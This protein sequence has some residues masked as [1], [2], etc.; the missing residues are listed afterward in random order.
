MKTYHLSNPSDMALLQP[1][2]YWLDEDYGNGPYIVNVFV[3]KKLGRVVTDGCEYRDW[4][5]RERIEY[6]PATDQD[7]RFH[8]PLEVPKF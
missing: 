8:G 5:I 6:A 3:H 7:I 1:G 2:Y 4:P